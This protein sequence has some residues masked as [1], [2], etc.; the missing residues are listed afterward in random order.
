M[1]NNGAYEEAARRQVD[2]MVKDSQRF[3]KTGGWGFQ[4]FGLKNRQ[5]ESA[6][7]RRRLNNASPA[8][9]SGRRMV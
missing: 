7:P 9:R 3:A 2:V 4:P 1:R 6:R 5:S 8:M